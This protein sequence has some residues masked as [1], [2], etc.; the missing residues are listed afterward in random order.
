MIANV[1]EIKKKKKP[2]G[3]TLFKKP[4]N[5]ENNLLTK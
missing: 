5:V 1:K 2:T 4:K 3:V